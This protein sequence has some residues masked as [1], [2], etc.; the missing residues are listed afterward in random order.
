MATQKKATKPAKK[1]AKPSKARAKAG[2]S[3]E[4]AMERKIKFVEA[5]IANGENGTD[6]AIKAGFSPKGAGV[7][8]SRLLKDINVQTILRERRQKLADKFALNTENVIRNLAC[9]VYFDPRKLYNADGSMKS[10]VDLDDETAAA[11]TGI[12]IVEMPGEKGAVPLFTRKVKW[13]DKNTAREQA[14]KHLGLFKQDNEQK[15]GELA[16]LVK[17]IQERSGK[18]PIKE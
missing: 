7:T 15:G 8:A 11:I 10:I 4:A 18:L 1:T 3:N 13:L 12:E 9:A 5:Y 14:M 2:T 6:A 17:L 16:E